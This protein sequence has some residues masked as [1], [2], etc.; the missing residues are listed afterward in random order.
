MRKVI[1]IIALFAISLSANTFTK[2]ELDLA[3][4][5]VKNY[6]MFEKTGNSKYIEIAYDIKKKFFNIL[7]KKPNSKPHQKTKKLLLLIPPVFKVYCATSLLRLNRKMITGKC[8]DVFKELEPDYSKYGHTANKQEAILENLV[9][10]LGE[11]GEYNKAKKVALYT[12]KLYPNQ[13]PTIFNLAMIYKMSKN[14]KDF[15]NLSEFGCF[16][17]HALL[18]S[19]RIGEKEGFYAPANYIHKYGIDKMKISCPNFNFRE[20]LQE[21]IKKEGF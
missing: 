7:N 10:R 12:L 15:K 4:K 14:I 19:D 16:F 13:A 21:L 8:Y 17:Y 18:E 9:R 11:Y 1:L 2:Y 20:K 3:N 5:L 6:N